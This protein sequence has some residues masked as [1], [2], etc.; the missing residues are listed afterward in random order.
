MSQNFFFLPHF[1][2]RLLSCL[3]PFLYIKQLPIFLL[4]SSSLPLFSEPYPDRLLS[5]PLHWRCSYQLYCVLCVAQRKDCRQ[6]YLSYQR[7]LTQVNRVFTDYFLW[8]LGHHILPAFSVG[9]SVPHL[10]CRFL[11]IS[12]IS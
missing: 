3:S 8:L 9:C 10:L 5:L 7:H 2:F 1:I 4:R 11:F 12:Q 6:S